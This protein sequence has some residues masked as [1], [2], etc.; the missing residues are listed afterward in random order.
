MVRPLKLHKTAQEQLNVQKLLQNHMLTPLILIM[1][2]HV[3]T[4]M[5]WFLVV[6]LTYLLLKMYYTLSQIEEKHKPLMII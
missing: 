5:C 1:S 6:K 3:Q 4:V 2:I